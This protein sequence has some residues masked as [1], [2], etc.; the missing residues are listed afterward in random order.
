ML[1][2]LAG[3]K[4]KRG[5]TTEVIT[6]I[7]T[8]IRYQTEAGCS[9]RSTNESDIKNEISKTGIVTNGDSKQFYENENNFGKRFWK[10]KTVPKSMCVF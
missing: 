2:E 3:A 5:V 8:D 7:G 9:H 4:L 6:A 1:S 10:A